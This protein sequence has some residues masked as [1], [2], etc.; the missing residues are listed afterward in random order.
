MLTRG[1]SYALKLL[2]NVAPEQISHHLQ[3]DKFVDNYLLYQLALASDLLSRQFH[4][5]LKGNGIKAS[6]WRVL[7]C[8]IDQPGLMLTEL[9]RQVLF[10]QSR[11]TKTID[12]MVVEG[13]VRKQITPDDR[14][15]TA[16]FVTVKG[17][18][19]V[20]PLIVK[21]KEHEEESLKVLN[22]RERKS[23]KNTLRKLSQR[24][25]R[26]LL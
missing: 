14:R 24:H 18:E 23:F 22:A 5:Y 3:G 16:L 7:A 19:L 21:A 17:A 8:L 12:Q 25:G 2:M 4:S 1:G 26:S 15:K 9:S 6:T 13:L 10:E 20:R 11:L